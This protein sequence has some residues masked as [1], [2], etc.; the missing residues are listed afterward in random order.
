M[1]GKLS[2]LL[3]FLCALTFVYAQDADLLIQKHR[4]TLE[5]SDME[6]ILLDGNH[7][8]VD[9][10]FYSCCDR[11]ITASVYIKDKLFSLYV[12][13]PGA[14]LIQKGILK[15]SH[16]KVELLICNTIYFQEERSWNNIVSCN[17]CSKICCP[18]CGASSLEG[19]STVRF[20]C[21][22]CGHPRGLHTYIPGR[23]GEKKAPKPYILFVFDITQTSVKSDYNEID[24]QEKESN[25][26]QFAKSISS[27]MMQNALENP[28][29]ALK[30]F[31]MGSKQIFILL[32]NN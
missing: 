15:A 17:T 5:K 12:A 16:D 20:G 14:E 4:Q 18:Q 23:N 6:H 1:A 30:K 27:Y 24:P 29:T 19:C 26:L 9:I 22:E 10:P 31:I 32:L 7:S 8:I 25:L 21:R 11:K 13:L 2:M 28:E 3:F